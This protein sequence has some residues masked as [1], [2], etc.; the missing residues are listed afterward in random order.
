VGDLHR[1]P[2]HQ[3]SEARRQF[4]G[5]RH[6]RPVDQDGDDRNI[7]RQRRFELGSSSRRRPWSSAAPAQSGPMT[8]T[9]ML[10]C[11]TLFSSVFT[12]SMPGAIASTSMN[13]SVGSK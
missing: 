12:K 8:A 1:L 9:K 5:F 2:P 10:H 13:K 6:V 7:A 3:G 11:A 4:L